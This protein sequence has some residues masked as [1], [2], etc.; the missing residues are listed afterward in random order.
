MIAHMAQVV[1]WTDLSAGHRRKK[2][3]VDYFQEV[4]EQGVGIVEELSNE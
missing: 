1:S 3:Y 2:E 4:V